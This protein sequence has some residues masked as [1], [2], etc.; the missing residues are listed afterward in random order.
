MDENIPSHKFVSVFLSVLQIL[1]G[2]R[3]AALDVTRVVLCI[4]GH[5]AW[6]ENVSTGFDSGEIYGDISELQDLRGMI[7]Q[8]FQVQDCDGFSP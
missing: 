4:R 6:G 7:K 2:C 1:R 5:S 8:N 3:H